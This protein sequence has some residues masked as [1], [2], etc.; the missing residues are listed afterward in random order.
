MSGKDVCKEIA[1]IREQTKNN[2][3]AATKAR[4]FVE[5]VA[6][7]GISSLLRR[8]PTNK[9]VYEPAYNFINNNINII[10]RKLIV[11]RCANSSDVK[12]TNTLIQP[13]SCYADI[14]ARCTNNKGIID[15]V[16]LDLAYKIT[17][18]VS[19]KDIQQINT[20]KLISVCEINT[21]I[22]VLADKV[23]SEEDLITLV[24]LQQAKD[25][26]SNKNPGVFS[27]NEINTNITKD[28][29]IKSFLECS[30]KTS[31]NQSNLINNC[32]PAVAFQLNDNNEMKEC[33]LNLGVFTEEEYKITNPPITSPSTILEPI[34]TFKTNTTNTPIN[35]TPIIDN[36]S[37][38]MNSIIIGGIVF[39]VFIILYLII[40]L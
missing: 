6:T 1:S 36:T 3:E 15:T 29:Y 20:N 39:M 23:K 34:T 38:L 11:N 35:T 8:K 17:D 26:V 27:C 12:Q 19:N 21:A 32:N 28:S 30:N 14:E 24:L 13:I 18:E 40:F 2:N 25:K 5:D 7:L 22:Q 31:V 4:E 37:Y 16:C 9:P 10:E 33:L